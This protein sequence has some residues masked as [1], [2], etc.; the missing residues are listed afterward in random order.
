M[1]VKDDKESARRSGIRPPRPRMACCKCGWVNPGRPILCSNCRGRK[2]W[3]EGRIRTNR[4]KWTGR[5]LKTEE[6]KA[7]AA[8]ELAF[9]NGKKNGKD[10]PS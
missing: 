8:D 2:W 10:G 5:Y 4:S 3:R 1:E 9:A 7:L 6:Q